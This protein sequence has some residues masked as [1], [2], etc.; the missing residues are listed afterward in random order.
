[1]VCGGIYFYS[2]KFDNFVISPFLD[3]P[4]NVQHVFPSHKALDDAWNKFLN[5]LMT[6]AMRNP[7]PVADGQM[8][9]IDLAFELDG[10][11]YVKPAPHIPSTFWPDGVAPRENSSGIES[12]PC[13]AWTFPSLSE[14]EWRRFKQAMPS[15]RRL[16]ATYKD[17]LESCPD[18]E[19]ES[20]NPLKPFVFVDVKFDDFA[21]WKKTPR[22]HWQFSDIGT[23][24]S[25]V[26]HQHAVSIL[27]EAKDTD[28]SRI[29]PLEYVHLMVYEIGN[30][31]ANDLVSLH[32][33]CTLPGFER[34]KPL[35]KDLK[36]FWEYGMVVAAAYAIKRKV[37]SILYT[38]QR[39]WS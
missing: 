23:F 7:V 33:V 28:K 1:V 11:R 15:A 32:Y 18:E 26:F 13:V 37:S 35:V 19:R 8:P 4:I 10:V 16:K 39:Y 3:H 31:K 38:R 21:R 20:S 34:K 17:W 27:E 30:D 22:K 25:K 12:S 36:L 24:S 2:D 14:D 5:D 29:V 9:A 6:D